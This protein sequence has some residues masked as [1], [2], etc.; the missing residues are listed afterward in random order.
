MFLV[1]AISMGGWGV[2]IG[3]RATD[4]ANDGLFGDG[5][6]ISGG[7]GYEDA[8]GAFEEAGVIIEAWEAGETTAYLYDDDEAL[9]MRSP[10]PRISIRRPWR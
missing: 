8:A 10:S 3:T 7:D 1:Y 2:S 6:F 5:W 9:P 4:W